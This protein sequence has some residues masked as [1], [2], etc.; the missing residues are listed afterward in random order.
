MI[1]PEWVISPPLIRGM[2]SVPR[3][4]GIRL[5]GV[6]GG[7][8]HQTLARTN[9][10]SWWASDNLNL[11]KEDLGSWSF[12]LGRLLDSKFKISHFSLP[13]NLLAL[14]VSDFF[15]PPSL[16]LL[17]IYQAL[18]VRKAL[19]IPELHLAGCVLWCS[20]KTLFFHSS[21]MNII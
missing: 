12:P 11:G 2:G 19:R 17:P 18:W 16:L 7:F 15:P 3:R 4:E 14:Y 6:V 13:I 21:G 1:G 20:R 5:Q 9:P 10:N 8:V